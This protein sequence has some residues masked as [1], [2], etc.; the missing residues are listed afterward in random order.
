MAKAGVAT[1]AIDATSDSLG[2]FPWIQSFLKEELAPYPGRGVMVARMVIAA[3]IT[4]VLVMMFRIPGGYEGALY[5]FMVARDDFRSTLKSGISVAVSYTIGV[6]FVITGA[7]LFAS[8]PSARF[9]W[10]AG[11]MFVV[12]FAF[13]TFQDFAVAVGFGIIMVLALPIWQ[14]PA[15]AETR[16]ELTLWQAL[17][18]VLGTLVT[19]LVEAVFRNLFPKDELIQGVDDR[20]LAVQELI[21]GYAEDQPISENVANRLVNYTM[22][23]VSGLRRRLARS[24]YERNYR[25]QLTAVVALTGRLVDLG[26][27]SAKHAHTLQDSDKERLVSLARGIEAVRKA[28]AESKV[29]ELDLGLTLGPSGI[30]LLSEIERTVSLIPKVFSGS[31]SIDA[32]FPSIL[33]QE[34][35]TSGF[36]KNDAFQNPA[37]ISFALRG[38]LAATLCYF[39]YEI[40]NW[41]GIA[42]SVTTCMLTALSNVGTSRQKQILRISGA[43][44]GG[45]ILGI[46]SQVF[47]LPY[48]D[49]IAEF[50]L[51]F[52]AVTAIAAWCSTS[53]QRLSYFGLQIANAYYLITV[54][55]FSF[56]PSLA[57]AR[58]RVVG[59]MLGLFMMWLAYHSTGNESAAQH[60]VEAFSA[61]LRAIAEL[62]L[63]PGSEL[64]DEAMKRIRMLRSQIGN[65]FEKVRAQADAVPLEFGA[66]R[67]QAM[68]N[69]ALIRSWL[70]QL[71]TIYLVEVALM[72][73][74]V[75]GAEEHVLPRAQVA[76]LR[77]NEECA[78]LLKQ[79]A[80]RIDGKVVEITPQLDAPLAQL[81][82]SLEEASLD[83]KG[84]VAALGQEK[85]ST[86]IR[87]ELMGL[88]QEIG[89]SNLIRTFA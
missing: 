61:N 66:G 34:E 85:L 22:V 46:G 31:E 25:D 83:H 86:S 84:F 87:D 3:V 24:R 30:P 5:A 42:T 77:F 56:E 43:V 10:F 82:R 13:D 11:S 9:L 32:Y 8:Y 20:L 69:R 70:P 41:R 35:K 51:L 53:S 67:A 33:D 14:M 19:V 38:C 65:N 60:M 50:S 23:G 47:I 72:Q 12:F 21:E 18:C 75:F 89:R 73:H 4:M 39:T 52:A 1:P 48:I 27:S 6:T 71:Q 29:P 59:I 58:D 74:R 2:F 16:V 57:T 49:S 15:T 76:Q 26:S 79:L 7:A 44:A 78:S 40:L 17:A 62:A 63:Q 36:F 88:A 68:G 55:G 37:H 54:S 80:D 28:L 64:P 45:L 81:S